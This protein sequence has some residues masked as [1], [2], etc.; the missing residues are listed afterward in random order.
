MSFW[1]AFHLVCVFT[2]YGIFIVTWAQGQDALHSFESDSTKSTLMESELLPEATESATRQWDCMT[3]E[4]APG[5]CKK[6]YECYRMF[7]IRNNLD[8]NS[9]LEDPLYEETLNNL[10]SDECSEDSF[11]RGEFCT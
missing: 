5:I 8:I 7:V 11:P 9:T 1:N 4:G 10:K 2:Y 3:P 6:L